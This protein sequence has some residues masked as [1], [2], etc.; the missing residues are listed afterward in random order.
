MRGSWNGRQP[1]DP[2]PLDCLN[3]FVDSDKDKFARAMNAMPAVIELGTIE[4]ERA[5]AELGGQNLCADERLRHHVC[6]DLK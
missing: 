6:R 2:C 1:F 4:Q 5:R 3:E